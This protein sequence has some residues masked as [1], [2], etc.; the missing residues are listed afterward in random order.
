MLVC[1]VCSDLRL[2]KKGLRV[3]ITLLILH[4]AGRT[5][6]GVW[7]LFL[8]FTERSLS[9]GVVTNGGERFSSHVCI[10]ICTV[11]SVSPKEWP[12]LSL[13]PSF[14][15]ARQRQLCRDGSSFLTLQSS[16]F[17]HLTLEDNLSCHSCSASLPWPLWAIKS[18]VYTPTPWWVCAVCTH[19]PTHSACN[20]EL[21]SL[22]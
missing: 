15:R 22:W 2:L 16:L 5:F 21:D 18:L 3:G 7:R 14:Y 1:V 6:E 8:I 13:K 10:S 20:S 9:R 12:V 11:S 19:K 17:C 4:G